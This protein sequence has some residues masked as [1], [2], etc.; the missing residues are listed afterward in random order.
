MLPNPIATFSSHQKSSIDRAERAS[1]SSDTTTI[2]RSIIAI[3]IASLHH[4]HRIIMDDIAGGHIE[5]RAYACY[6]QS[7]LVHYSGSPES[8]FTVQ[9]FTCTDGRVAKWIQGRSLV[10]TK[11][12]LV[13]NQ[14]FHAD[15]VIKYSRIKQGAF[16]NL[17][18][19]AMA[20]DQLTVGSLHSK[21]A[22][23]FVGRSVLVLSNEQ[24]QSFLHLLGRPDQAA[25][26]HAAMPVRAPKKV[27]RWKSC[28]SSVIPSTSKGRGG[29]DEAFHRSPLAVNRSIYSNLKIIP[30]VT[31]DTKNK[32][33]F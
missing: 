12:S 13:C 16:C 14:L 20:S 1:E 29:D 32:S 31:M 4:H 24:A 7:R 21:A 33:S 6:D 28:V 8:A 26:L 30:A 11:T 10:S 19:L 18:W 23:T 27:V 22:R 5:A 17:T 2:H 9:D 15:D 25:E 3:A